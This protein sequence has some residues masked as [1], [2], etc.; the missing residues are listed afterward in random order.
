MS[1]QMLVTVSA[2]LIALACSL[3]G[4]FLVLR[5]M[6]MMADA[7]THSVLPG[8]VAAY[9]LAHGP[10]LA[11][12]LIGS[13]LAGLLTAFLVQALSKTKRLKEDAAIGLVFPTLFAIGVYVITRSFSNLHIDTDSVLYG[14][15]AMV[16]FDRL[17]VGGQDWGP[18][19]M[20]IGGV[21]LA[22]NALV[23]GAL[24]KEMK[25]ST[26]DPELTETL[27]YS[28]GFLHY[29]LMVLVAIT[30]VG[31]FSAVGAVLAVALIVIPAAA[32]L[33]IFRR[34]G[35][36][37]VGALVLG[38]LGS[39]LGYQSA[40]VWDV[41]I[42]GMIAV[43]LGLLFL[44]AAVFA[45]E[46]GLLMRWLRHRRHKAQF[47]AEMLAVHLATHEGTPAESRESRYDHLIDELEWTHEY[48]AKAI[49]EARRRGAISVEGRQLI[50]TDSGRQWAAN[51][52]RSRSIIPA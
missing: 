1:P 38:G 2:V 34:L 47:A 40:H 52:V 10:N 29:L 39:V 26:F 44:A 41:S 51:I 18:K 35:A 43:T 24:W 32:S 6:A 7:I 16:P 48:A 50:L 4:V 46:K 33:L 45:P 13:A 49:A 12:G 3:C 22:I 31:A 21:L 25:L 42:S 17:M 20:W 11:A 14:E 19:A 30:A 15:L 28:T 36:V 9:V 23:L 37:L 27:G 8:I 5:R